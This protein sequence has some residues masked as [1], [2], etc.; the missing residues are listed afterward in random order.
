[1]LQA[2]LLLQVSDGTLGLL[3]AFLMCC[4]SHLSQKVSRGSSDKKCPCTEHIAKWGT[5]KQQINITNK[6]WVLKLQE[7]ALV[8]NKNAGL[9]IC[10]NPHNPV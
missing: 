10:A 2:L 5:G 6:V 1:M 4:D 3:C 9:Q 7:F 8:K